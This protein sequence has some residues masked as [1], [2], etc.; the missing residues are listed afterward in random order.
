MQIKI[1]DIG[2]VYASNE[3]REYFKRMAG[4]WVT[5]ETDYLFNNQYNTATHRVMDS[6]VSAVRNDA[7]HNRGVCKYCGAQ[8]TTG[9]ICTAHKECK[10]HGIEWFTPAN[11]FFLK[12]PNG[13][14]QPD[15]E[16]LSI[17]DDRLKL[18]TYYLENYPSLGYY[19]LHN[20]RKTINFKFDGKQ[21]WVAN[22]IGYTAKNVLP[23]PVEVQSQ[24][25]N[26]IATLQS[27]N[28]NHFATQPA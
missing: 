1:S 27:R 15:K 25:T 24:L 22:G 3:T 11:T 6:Q 10:E 17:H 28:Y 5:V 9:Q 4:K 7:R 14:L 23:V 26:A 12:H 19:R 13:L 16:S 21:Y 18:G 2:Y 20:C 8:L